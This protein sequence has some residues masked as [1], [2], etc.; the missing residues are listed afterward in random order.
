MPHAVARQKGDGLALEP[1]ERDR[2]AGWAKRRFD[3]FLAQLL[4]PFHGIQA[5]TTD[6]SKYWFGVHCISFGVLIATHLTC[7]PWPATRI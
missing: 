6:N 1:A 4:Q 2:G 3:L 5:G 7:F